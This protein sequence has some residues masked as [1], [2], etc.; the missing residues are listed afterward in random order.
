MMLQVQLQWQQKSYRWKWLYGTAN[1]QRGCN[2]ITLKKQKCPT[3]PTSKDRKQKGRIES[4]YAWSNA[5]EGHKFKSILF[6]KQLW[7]ASR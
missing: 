2:W 7:K 5:D 1:L 4:S 6:T 3:G